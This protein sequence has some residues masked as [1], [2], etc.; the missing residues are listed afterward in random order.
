MRAFWFFGVSVLAATLTF[1]ASG[2]QP[3]PEPSESQMESSFS[4]FFSKLERGAV[5][6]IRF[7]SFKKHSCKPSSAVS[8]HYCSFT[9]SAELPAEQLS[10]FPTD[11]TI[12]GTFLSEDDGL[13]RFEMVIG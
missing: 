8:G 12:S 10:I 1:A 7:A 11:A 3:R 2:S 6:E 9:Y 4:Q 13:I 5:S